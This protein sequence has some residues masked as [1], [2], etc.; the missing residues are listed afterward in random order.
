MYKISRI[1]VGM[2]DARMNDRIKNSFRITGK[3]VWTTVR[4]TEQW[5]IGM[6]KD[7]RV[8]SN[9]KNAS[10]DLRNSIR[11]ILTANT[12]SPRVATK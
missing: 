8:L 9:M 12:S 3:Q 4:E 1:L 11:N 7:V 5:G 2:K 6:T 10:S